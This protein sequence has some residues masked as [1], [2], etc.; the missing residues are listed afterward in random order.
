MD[1]LNILNGYIWSMPQIV[2][3]LGTGLLF[4]L[5]MKCTQIR[6]IPTMI[7]LLFSGKKSE[8]G[9]SSFQA[10]TLAIAG[11]VGVGNI[12]G[13]ATAVCMGGP[14]SI[15]WMWVIAIIGSITTFVECSLSQLHKKVINGE[16]RGGWM[17]YIGDRFKFLGAFTAV[18]FA[19]TMPFT[20]SS[21]HLNN[22]AVAVS[23]AFGTP[24]LAVG[25]AIAVI[26]AAVIFGGAKRIGRVAEL[27][28]PVMAVGYIG[29]ALVIIFAHITE[30]PDAFAAIVKGAFGKDQMIGAAMGSAMIWGTKRALFSSET[31]LTTATPSAAS[32]EVS[33]PAKQG[34][35]Q[36][37]SIYI[38]TLFVC[39]A[40]GLMLVVSGCYN[41]QDGSGNMLYMGLGEAIEAGPVWVARAMETVMP[42]G[43]QFIAIAI[44]FFGF[45]SIMNHNYSTVSAV[46]YFFQKKN[47]PKWAEYLVHMCFIGGVIFGATMSLDASWALGDVLL[48]SATWI[49]YIFLLASAGVAIKL[50]KDFEEQKRQGLDPVFDPDKFEGVRGFDFDMG[51]WRTIRDKYKSGDLKN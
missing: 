22:I 6:M 30:V 50:L 35:V 48:G 45:T 43:S 41:V 8:H 23:N 12:A 20:Q 14:G 49:N 37:F 19:I 29:V 31:G 9:L 5:A 34:L 39:T 4:T 13:V 16:Y 27:V 44:F 38:D 2:L 18:L 28:V 26:L 1:L 15:F 7:K 36:T 51:I 3:L 46:M 11:R 33:H 47:F 17:Y 10:F 25:I 32:A 40:T 42:W 24:K 21:L